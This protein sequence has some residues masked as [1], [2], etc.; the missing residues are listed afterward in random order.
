MCARCSQICWKHI[1]NGV[2]LERATK[3]CHI[4]IPI[5]VP[6]SGWASSAWT[7][8]VKQ[9]TARRAKKAIEREERICLDWARV[10]WRARRIM[11]VVVCCRRA[12]KATTIYLVG[13]EKT[14]VSLKT[15]PGHVLYSLYTRFAVW[16]NAKPTILTPS[17]S[18]NSPFTTN[19]ANTS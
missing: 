11:M 15:W 17:C 6:Y 7:G 9:T 18:V 1:V 13:N 10:G 19:S 14:D 12:I 3:A 5:T 16:N 4:P 8:W 2:G